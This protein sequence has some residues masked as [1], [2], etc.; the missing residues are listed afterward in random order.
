MSLIA[1]MMW[2]VSCVHCIY[3]IQLVSSQ[4]LSSKNSCTK[5]RYIV[6]RRWVQ[7]SAPFRNCH[8][9]SHYLAPRWKVIMVGYMRFTWWSCHCCL[10]TV[11]TVHL[12]IVW[13]APC[14]KMFYISNTTHGST[15]WDRMYYTFNTTCIGLI[16][17]IIFKGQLHKE[18]LHYYVAFLWRWVQG[19][20]P[21][22][23]LRAWG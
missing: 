9:C 11:H 3:V 4:P 13:R 18:T 6:V 17:A 22:R 14:D 20:A 10:C 1:V 12:A 16:V 7:G 2:F 23:N 19:S 15:Q 21:F 5:K 8:H